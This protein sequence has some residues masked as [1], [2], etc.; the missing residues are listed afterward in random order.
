LRA[1]HAARTSPE[2]RVDLDATR[3]VNAARHDPA[4]NVAG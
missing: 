2:S 1:G 4:Q 3:P